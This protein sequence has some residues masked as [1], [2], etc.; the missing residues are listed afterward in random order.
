MHVSVCHLY[1]ERTPKREVHRVEGGTTG[2]RNSHSQPV[3]RESNLLNNHLE[4][5]IE[6]QTELGYQEAVGESQLLFISSSVFS[7]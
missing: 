6:Q 5:H 7:S 2:R 1:G 4:E 3:G